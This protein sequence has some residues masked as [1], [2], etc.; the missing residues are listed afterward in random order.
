[1]KKLFWTFSFLVFLI[2]CTSTVYAEVKVTSNIKYG[3]DE[4]QIID[5]YQPDG[6][7]QGNKYPVMIWIHGGGWR[8]GSMHESI[9]RDIMTT[10][11]KQ[12]IVVVGVDY[13]LSPKYMHPVLVQDVAA[14]I[15]WVYRNIASFGGDT[16]RMS[17]M[18]HSSGAHLVALVATNPKYLGT[19]GLSPGKILANVF[20]IDTAGYDLTDPAQSSRKLIHDAFGTDPLVLKDA[21]PLLNV[22]MGGSY[23]PFIMGVNKIRDDAVAQC[24]ALQKKLE[25]EGVAAEVIIVDYPNLAPLVAHIQICKEIANLDCDLTRT[26]LRRVLEKN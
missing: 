23:P 14:G 21:S 7:Q 24:Q 3:S 13:R 20:P 19:Y 11:A 10:W 9:Y 15:N 17:L 1:M 2:G 16:N 8:S 4:A 12:G 26:L 6:F 5:V 22:Q 25:N 18:G